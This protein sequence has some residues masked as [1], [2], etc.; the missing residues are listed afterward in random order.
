MFFIMR[1]ISPARNNTMEDV[2]L[3]QKK[4]PAPKKRGTIRV[5]VDRCKGCWYCIAYCPTKVLQ[6]SETLNEKGYHPPVLVEN[7]PEKVCIACHMCEMVCPDFAII[8][9]ELK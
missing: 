5:I 4:P 7:P 2:K 8:V 3:T 9:E 6:V 1:P